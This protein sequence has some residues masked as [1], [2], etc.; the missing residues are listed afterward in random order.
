MF[1]VKYGFWWCES[2]DCG[3]DDFICLDVYLIVFCVDYCVVYNWD[4]M[5]EV[6]VFYIFC[7]DMIEIVVLIGVYWLIGDYLWLGGGYLWGKVDDDLCMVDVFKSG[8]FINI[9]M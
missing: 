2:V 5:V 4:L 3:S 6:C 9:I 1:F 7:V 8:L